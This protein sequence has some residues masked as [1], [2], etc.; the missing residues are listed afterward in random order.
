[1]ATVH[2]DNQMPELY[3]EEVKTVVH[4]HREERDGREKRSVGTES[5]ELDYSQTQ[6]TLT[7]S[8]LGWGSSISLQA[9]VGD[10][11]GDQ[12]ERVPVFTEELR[13]GSLS[14][15]EDVQVDVEGS[16]SLVLSWTNPNTA[17]DSGDLV[18]L[19][20]RLYYPSR[21]QREL[22]ITETDTGRFHITQTDLQCQ[23]SCQLWSLNY[24][25]GVQGQEEGKVVGLLD[26]FPL[27]P[28]DNISVVCD[29]EE[30]ELS[31]CLPAS[32]PHIQGMGTILNLRNSSHSSV[33]E[34]E[35]LNLT[36]RC[37]NVTFPL[38]LA[39]HL[40]LQTYIPGIKAGAHSQ[41]EP[42]LAPSLSPLEDK[43]WL[44]I[45]L[46]LL[47]IL[48]ILGTVLCLRR[49]KKCGGGRGKYEVNPSPLSPQRE[50]F[51]PSAAQEEGLG[52]ARSD[53][54]SR[55]TEQSSI[56]SI[57]TLRRMCKDIISD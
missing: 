1:M 33:W 10:V 12:T 24:S 22:V 25:L 54:G 57:I 35:S 31:W 38:L 23:D 21:D 3:A 28:P 14:P 40:T 2:W 30:C 42:L 15:V 29:E 6:T 19:V 41:E 36:D 27:L 26:T 47:L 16:E 32:Q 13:T 17:L 53:T 39:T 55:D 50:S 7:I 9:K 34:A 52:R 46:S 56:V 51:L 5:F 11:T 48:Y 4:L 8:S 20:L 18:P 49:V 43:L 37:D 45:G 44:I